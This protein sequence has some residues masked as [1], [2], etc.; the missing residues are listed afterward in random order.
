MFKVT[1]KHLASCVYIQY[2]YIIGSLSLLWQVHYFWNFIIWWMPNKCGVTPVW[3][4]TM[5]IVYILSS[6]LFFF[7]ST[8]FPCLH[9][10]QIVS[11]LS[12]ILLIFKFCLSEKVSNGMKK[13]HNFQLAGIYIQLNSKYIK[14][15]VRAYESM[16]GNGGKDRAAAYIHKDNNNKGHGK[17]VSYSRKSSEIDNRTEFSWK[18]KKKNADER[19]NRNIPKNTYLLL[20]LFVWFSRSTDWYGRV[21]FHML[22]SN[23][24]FYLCNSVMHSTRSRKHRR[25]Q[26]NYID[27]QNKPS[28]YSKW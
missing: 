27:S 6:F 16:H 5:C 19:T 21:W 18:R 1:F 7:V 25:K 14:V 2:T 3:N 26:N 23:V 10:I 12:N 9:L 11:I 28:E 13:T 22:L 20:Y 8:L 15:S 24:T 4:A 17:I